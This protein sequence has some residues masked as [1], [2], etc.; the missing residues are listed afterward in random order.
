MS[1]AIRRDFA[2]KA[3]LQLYHPRLTASLS[4]QLCTGIGEWGMGNGKTYLGTVAN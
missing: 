2:I 1:L 4:R 3:I